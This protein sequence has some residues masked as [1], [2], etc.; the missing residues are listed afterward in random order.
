VRDDCAVRDALAASA[1]LPA[2]EQGALV[3]R[4]RA[5][6]SNAAASGRDAADPGRVPHLVHRCARRSDRRRDFSSLPL[7]ARR[8]GEQLERFQA[9]FPAEQIKVVIYDD[10]RADGAAIL[11]ELLDFLGLEEG[12]DLPRREANPTVRIRSRA[13]HDLLHAVSVGHGPVSRAL[14]GSIKTVTSHGLRRSF[15]HTAQKRLLFTEPEP[16]DEE[17]MRQI[18]LRYRPEVLA[19]SERLGRDLVALWGYDRLD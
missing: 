14:K 18:R 15:L 8:G 9:V 12:A 1:D 5:A 3:L 13:M 2:A 7:V 4:D 19:L 16:P 10:F 17:L 11:G 6:D